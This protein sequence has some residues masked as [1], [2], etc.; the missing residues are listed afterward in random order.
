MEALNATSLR[1]KLHQFIDV[2][3]AEKVTAIY[4]SFQ[5]DIECTEDEID[6]ALVRAIK[7]GRKDV[8]LNEKEQE[9]FESW[10]Q[11]K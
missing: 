6:V 8:R 9:N 3:G 4:T 11:T 2:I 5:K 7:A 1:K 10:L